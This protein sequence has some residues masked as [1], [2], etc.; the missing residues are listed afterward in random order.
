MPVTCE[1]CPH[2]LTLTDE[3]LR[4]FGAVYKVAPPLRTQADAD[5]LLEGLKDGFGGLP[6]HRSR[7]AHPRRKEQ[8]CCAHS[9]HRVHRLAFPLMWTSFGAEL[10]LQ[11][12]VELLTVD[13][14]RVLNWPAPSLEAGQPADFTLLDLETVRPVDPATFKSKAKFNPWV[15][16]D[17][18]G[19]PMLTVV[20]GQVAYRREVQR[21]A[22]RSK[23]R[24]GSARFSTAGN[25]A[26]R[27]AR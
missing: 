20:D 1:V 13:V 8:D 6:R 2:H 3:A 24:P 9:R 22:H 5:H 12:L 15:G 11:K 14:A 18:K 26:C 25:L 23:S 16:Q 21:P 7:A 19:W 10:G 17:L 27:S 4:G